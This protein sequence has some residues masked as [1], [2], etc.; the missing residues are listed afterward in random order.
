M[1]HACERNL[2]T[3]RVDLVIALRQ[4]HLTRLAGPDGTAGERFNVALVQGPQERSVFRD[5]SQASSI[6]GAQFRAAGAATLLGLPMKELANR[7]V[8]LGDLWASHATDLRDAPQAQA[9]A[10]SRLRLL[11]HVLLN[12]LDGATPWAGDAPI[13]WAAQQFDASGN[14]DAGRVEA[15]RAGLGWSNQRFIAQFKQRTGL[16]P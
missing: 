14:A 11:H 15:V 9:D 3:G 16:T 5:T 6:A 2:P 12:R 13:A 8:A 10:P 7:T 1:P 4:A